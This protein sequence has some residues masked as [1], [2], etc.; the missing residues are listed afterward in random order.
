MNRFYLES[1]NTIKI[2]ICH[3][4][5]IIICHFYMLKVA[6]SERFNNQKDKEKLSKTVKYNAASQAG[7]DHL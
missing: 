3:H 4:Y 2:Q 1:M 5:N 6:M 7:S